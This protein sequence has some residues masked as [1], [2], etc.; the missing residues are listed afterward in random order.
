MPLISNVQLCLLFDDSQERET[1]L[2]PQLGNREE[3]VLTK[4]EEAYKDEVDQLKYHLYSI[5]G[6]WR[7]RPR[8][9]ESHQESVEH[10]LI[11]C[12]TV[13]CP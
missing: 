2:I 3:W 9:E 10:I 1:D 8:R 12:P 11:Q 4:T 7:L 6:T 5:H 13:W